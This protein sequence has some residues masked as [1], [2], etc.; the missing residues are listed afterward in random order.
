MLKKIVLR[1]S[2]ALVTIGTTV[3]LLPG[4]ANVLNLGPTTPLASNSI[5]ISFGGSSAFKV[6]GGFTTCAA[7]RTGHFY[8]AVPVSATNVNTGATSVVLGLGNVAVDLETPITG[9]FSGTIPTNLNINCSALSG[10]QL[11]VTAAA[12]QG[13]TAMN[14]S[15]TSGSA[16]FTFATID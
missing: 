14:G 6:N 7:G 3:A 2:L 1:A 4:G 12:H 10:S 15:K 16:I 5:A 8:T 13:N 11:T 9:G